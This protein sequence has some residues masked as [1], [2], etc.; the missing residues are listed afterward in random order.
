VR[1][2]DRVVT[3]YVVDADGAL[4]PANAGAWRI[5]PATGESDL[6]RALARLSEQPA[7]L[8][9]A[10]S[11]YGPLRLG[12]ELIGLIPDA[13]WDEM[14]V[15]LGQLALP[16]W[17]VA[18]DWIAHGSRD[19]MPSALTNA[20]PLIEAAASLPPSI[21]RY[22]DLMLAGASS[23]DRADAMKEVER[24]AAGWAPE[25]AQSDTINA[26]D[27]IARG[28]S[29]PRSVIALRGADAARTPC[30]DEAVAWA[31]RFF[32]QVQ[33]VLAGEAAQPT[34]IDTAGMV[35]SAIAA[36]PDLLSSLE[37]ATDT[38]DDPILG[39]LVAQ[40][41]SE[42]VTGWL[43]ACREMRHWVVAVDVRKRAT[44]AVDV[45]NGAA[46]G[47]LRLSDLD[48]LRSLI[49]VLLDGT[50]T[51]LGGANTAGELVELL[52]PRLVARLRGRLAAARA[53]PYPADRVVGTYGRALWAVWFELTDERPP[54]MCAGA[55]CGESFP[56][57]GNRRYCDVHRLIRDRT[58]KQKTGMTRGQFT[59]A[60]A[61]G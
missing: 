27:A 10:A 19:A 28:S 20:M 4:R 33:A 11:T 3:E 9:G 48:D 12:T 45:W 5:E 16:K 2:I 41:R 36:F 23:S 46:T 26:L 7:A 38:E 52:M 31:V 1:S 59:P 58:R 37:T 55:G 51:G 42:T 29:A 56:A 50:T 32:V 22:L 44:A 60:P 14:G 13:A 43:A 18:S 54:Q 6:H 39:H 17:I 24:D 53:W 8:A 61:S 35:G 47:K 40:L 30:D 21:R 57:H 15:I 49:P 34:G 25:V